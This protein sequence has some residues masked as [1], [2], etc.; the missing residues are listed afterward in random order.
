[1]TATVTTRERDLNSVSLLTAGV[2][3][4]T[5]TMT[6]GAMI[7]V[8]FYRSEGKVWGHIAI[9]S[10]LW[11]STAL[12]LASSATLERARRA[13]ALNRQVLGFRL[14]AWTAALATA[15]LI[16]QVVAWFQVL[17]S[18]IQ[19]AQNPHSWFIFL[20][21]AL[22]GLH[23]LLGLGGIAYLVFRTREPVS[24]PRYQ[25]KTRVVANGVSLFWHYL[26]FLWLVLFGLLLT[27]HR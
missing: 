23:I 17:R 10:V 15:F 19:L 11:L 24:G 2:V 9:P 18:G 4:A 22:H 20:F 5:V 21:T 25:T 26:D 16:G 6:F 13:L 12:L 3:L 7:A 8:F 27:W 1:V 14:L